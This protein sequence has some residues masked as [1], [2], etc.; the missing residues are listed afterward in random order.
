MGITNFE[1]LFQYTLEKIRK[2]RPEITDEVLT[3]VFNQTFNESLLKETANKIYE[4]LKQSMYKNLRQE[5]LFYLEF[6]SRI[7]QRWLTPLSLLDTMIM[8]SEEICTDFI[9]NTSEMVVEDEERPSTVTSLR[10]FTVM[11]LLSKIII[12][13]KEISYLL[14]G[15]FSDA[16]ISRWRTLHEMD[17]VLQIFTHIYNDQ[18]KVNDIALRYNDSVVLEQFKEYKKT[19]R[20]DNNSELYLELKKDVQEI[21]KKYGENFYKSYE[22]ARPLISKNGPIYFK[23]LEKL[24][25]N[26]H[27]EEYYQQANYQI[28]GSPSGVYYS[29]GEIEDNRIS[30]ATFVF[31]PS[32]YGLSL[33][34]Q[35]TAIS[36]SKSI[37]SFLL[38]K[39]S[40]DNVIQVNVLSLILNDILDEFNSIQQNILDEELYDIQE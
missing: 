23:D 38:I 11:K 3:Q 28:H 15:G 1:K 35:L 40:I 5:Q 26:N 19:Y 22:W 27:L 33:P 2:E 32:N 6:T 12:T 17:T 31:G 34:G 10:F 9:D 39:I 30:S 8:L 20:K 16:A 21:I 37:A 25:N 7:S 29:N 13:A 14:K 24:S 36:L 4:S 18:D